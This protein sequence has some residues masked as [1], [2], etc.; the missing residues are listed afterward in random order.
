[1]DPLLIIS[2][3]GVVVGAALLAVGLRGRKLDDHPICRKCRFDLVGVWPGRETCPECG[4]GLTEARA[5]RIGNRRPIRWMMG[6]GAAALIAATGWLSI[7]GGLFLAGPK[8]NPYKPFW[9]LRYDAAGPGPRAAA[10]IDELDRRLNGGKLSPAQS[11]SI[12]GDAIAAQADRGR[13][14][15]SEWASLLRTAKL[16]GQLSPGEIEQYWRNG[17]EVE[18]LIRRAARAGRPIPMK[19]RILGTR[20]PPGVMV[21]V[22]VEDLKFR[23]ADG[24]AQADGRDRVVIASVTNRVGLDVHTVEPDPARSGPVTWTLDYR[25]SVMADVNGE[26]ESA[27]WTGSMSG[28]VGIGPADKPLIRVAQRDELAEQFHAAIDARVSL[29]PASLGHR[30]AVFHRNFEPLPEAVTFD[31][32]LRWPDGGGVIRETWIGSCNCPAG[33]RGGGGAGQYSAELVNVPEGLSAADVVL[34]ASVDRAEMDS[35]VMST[36]AGPDLRYEQV[37][38]DW[39]VEG[40]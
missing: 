11:A 40:Q 17:I 29:H 3:G 13:P 24:P 32:Y 12:I 25:L 22:R 27:S 4:A 16:Q 8:A 36:W 26:K 39:R 30:M 10:S 23:L 1:M 14:W 31:V 2:L 15:H 18:A 21:P 5:R 37:P 20:L 35:A 9:L 28:T 34:R 38:I 19:I 33:E 6:A 7:T